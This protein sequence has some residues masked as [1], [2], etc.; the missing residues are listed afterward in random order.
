MP[1]TRRSDPSRVERRRSSQPLGNR[2]DPQ[3]GNAGQVGSPNRPDP[4]GRSGQPEAG[5]PTAGQ[6]MADVMDDEDAGTQVLAASILLSLLLLR[7]SAHLRRI[8]HNTLDELHGHILT[9]VARA[10]LAGIPRASTRTAANR[11]SDEVE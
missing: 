10:D 9:M 4:A 1:A 3:R 6:L 2:P 5:R 11:L 8:N 7:Y